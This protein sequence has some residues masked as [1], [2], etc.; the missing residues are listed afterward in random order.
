MVNPQCGSCQFLSANEGKAGNIERL[1]G[2]QSSVAA[3]I[4]SKAKHAPSEG[5]QT[6][7]AKRARPLSAVALVA[8]AIFGYMWRKVKRRYAERQM[9][10]PDGDQR[11]NWLT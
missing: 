3:T 1:R 2:A 6:K 9:L 11:S 4:Q 5:A 7:G 10:P 8:F